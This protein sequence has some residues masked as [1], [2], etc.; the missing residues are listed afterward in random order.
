[1][2]WVCLFVC[3]THISLCSYWGCGQAAMNFLFPAWWIKT[4]FFK[5]SIQ[6]GSGIT[7]ALSRRRWTKTNWSGFHGNVPWGTEV[8]ASVTT[9]VHFLFCP[10]PIPLPVPWFRSIY[11]SSIHQVGLESPTPHVQAR[12]SD[13]A[14][15]CSE[16]SWLWF[17]TLSIKTSDWYW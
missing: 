16:A 5:G 7:S 9:T 10:F 11:P 4:V 12:E 8:R 3:F 15:C 17:L 6:S 2:F 13:P 14:P 1:M